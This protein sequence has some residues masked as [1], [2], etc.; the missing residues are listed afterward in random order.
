MRQRPI[1]PTALL[2]LVLAGGCGGDEPVAFSVAG[3]SYGESELLGL[4]DSRRELLAELTAFAAIIAEGR[5]EEFVEPWV[6]SARIER[7]WEQVQAERVLEDE[8]F[9]DAALE[10][11][12]RLDPDYQLSVRH[13]IVFADRYQADEVR[14]AAAAKAQ[15]A[16][17]R[18]RSGEPFPQVAAEVSD[19]PGAESREGLLNPGV[20][21]TW[22]DEFWNAAIAL[23]VGG[24]SEVVETQYGFHV[25]RL[26]ARDTLPF[27]SARPDVALEVARILAPLDA[28]APSVDSIRALAAQVG[29]DPADAQF[30]DVRRRQVLEVEAQAQ[31]L[32][33][34]IGFSMD[35]VG[36]AAQA[37]LAAGG[38]N[39]ELA[40]DLVQGWR[41]A[42]ERI[43]SIPEQYSGGAGSGAVAQTSEHPGG[44][45][46]S[47]ARS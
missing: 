14:S 1:L 26:E 22:V 41:P 15:D 13:L 46:V 42:L 23:Q 6:D 37:A 36:E 34:P 29:F 30:E 9:S 8:G 7:M 5:T 12:Y 10:A 33:M 20:E 39:A 16:L 31:L 43:H 2:L 25:L 35:R 17:E 38:Q 24:I 47:P 28:P 18:I 19:E 3:V 44:E 40:R 11:R 27:A 4:S 32:G 45:T 21:D